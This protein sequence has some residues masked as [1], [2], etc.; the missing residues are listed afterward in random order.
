MTNKDSTILRQSLHGQWSSRIV[1]I[2]AV[3]GSAV[4]LGNIWRFPYMAGINGGGAYVLI[5]LLCIFAIG[6]PI[7]ISE[8]M[9]GRRGRRNPMTSMELLG[10]EETGIKSWKYA[11][12]IGLLAGFLILSYYSV[13]AGWTLNYFMLTAQGLFDGIGPSGVDEVFNA[14]TLSIKTQV[15][16]HTIFMALTILIIAKGIKAGLER[17]VT[18]MMPALFVIMLVL[19]IYAITQGNFLEGL[20]F[21]FRPDF[22]KL[23][24]SSL[25]SAM[26]QAFFTLSLGMG[27]V[28]TYG[29]YLPKK[30]SI[31]NSTIAIILCDT[32]IALLAGMIIFPIVFSYGLEPAEGPGLIF[33]TLPL[34]FG[35]I[36]GGTIFGSLFFILLGFAALTSAISLLEP[37][38]AWMIEQKNVSRKVSA[39]TIGL[40]IWALGLLTVLSFNELSDFTFWKG[41]V[42]ENFEHLASNILLPTSGLLFTVFASWFMSKKSSS[43][44]LNGE[45]S[46]QYRFWR[47][48]ARYIAPIAVLII[49]LNVIGIF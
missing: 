38:V 8:I 34:A 18:I 48:L 40:G 17:A 9:L 35:Q 5:Y 33:K 16:F 2:L 41:T 1:F 42:F 31:F 22:S 49:F 27:C 29:A 47:F 25:L 37:S 36:S 10:L 13:I 32:L 12:V 4:G 30:E 7:M 20:R 45:H 43:E 11:G 24:G 39:I 3:S 21:M 28:F 26:G 46:W 6:L 23:D 15:V 14:L 44:E 19:I